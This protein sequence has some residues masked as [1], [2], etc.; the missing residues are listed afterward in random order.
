MH[1]E[2]LILYAVVAGVVVL[3]AAS[4]V[5][6][7]IVVRRRSKRRAL[8]WAAA[9]RER[10]LR[11]EPNPLE[12][13]EGGSP[14]LLRGVFDG[15]R[16]ELR[17]VLRG[18]SGDT[19]RVTRLVAFP[20]PAPPPWLVA[21]KPA[22]GRAT[23]APPHDTSIIDDPTEY[24]AI[25]VTRDEPIG[26]AELDAALAIHADA[27][28]VVASILRQPAVK[29]ALLEAIARAGHVR[30][31]NGLVIVDRPGS[32]DSLA[33]LDETARAATAVAR[34]L[35]AAVTALGVR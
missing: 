26:D 31:S 8:A 27:N 14:T 22:F 12:P 32:L 35:G 5:A 17:E 4:M 19:T 25:A 13:T 3:F 7:A 21:Y 2:D 28:G 30:V 34:A 10:G 6:V 29:A 20:E 1:A 33:Q 9:V 18:S 15:V 16:V 24:S 11:E 23:G